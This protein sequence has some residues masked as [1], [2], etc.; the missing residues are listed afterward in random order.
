MTE[1]FFRLL[2]ENQSKWAEQYKKQEE[3]RKKIQTILN[4]KWISKSFRDRDW[5][6]K[7]LIKSLQTNEQELRT[8][9]L[10]KGFHPQNIF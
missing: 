6:K 4:R 5:I 10:N 7:E 3:E 1:E 9:L 8:T 2:V